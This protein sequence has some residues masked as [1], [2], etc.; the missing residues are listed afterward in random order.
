MS[1]LQCFGKS[2][3]SI[4]VFEIS[5][6][7]YLC[8]LK[9]NKTVWIRLQE[10]MTVKIWDIFKNQ[11]KPQKFANFCITFERLLNFI[12]SIPLNNLSISL[13]TAQTKSLHNSR[14]GLTS[15]SKFFQSQFIV[16]ILVH[17]IKYF[18]NSFLRRI[19]I[20]RLGLL[21]LKLDWF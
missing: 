4:I 8:K 5:K 11:T 14:I 19:F 18:I 20:L 2:M 10:K 7:I 16:M 9:S 17:L 13:V 12:L 21:T 3:K 15:I 1:L 6:L